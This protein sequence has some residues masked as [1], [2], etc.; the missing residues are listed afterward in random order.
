M[1][2]RHRLEITMAK[3]LDVFDYLNAA[4]KED[5]YTGLIHSAFQE[6]DVFKARFC[7]FFGAKFDDKAKLLMRHPFYY[8]TTIT[9]RKIGKDGRIAQEPHRHQRQIPDLVLVTQDKIC[10]IESKLFSSE[11]SFQTERYGDIRFLESIKQEKKLAHLNLETAKLHSHRCQSLSDQ[12]LFYMTINGDQAYNTSFMSVTWSDLI[13]A[14]LPE[15]SDHNEILQP[16]LTQMKSRFV[17]Y[18]L[19]RSEIVAAK[20]DQALDPFLRHSSKHFL[21]SKDYLLFAFFDELKAIQTLLKDHLGV[22]IESATIL[23]NRQ[24]LIAAQDWED[25]SIEAVLETLPL[26]TPVETI[27][28]KLIDEP[29]PFSRPVIKVINNKKICVCINYEPNPYLSET[30]LIKRYGSKLVERLQQGKAQ[31][32]TDLTALGIVTTSSLLQVCKTEFPKN[33]KDL[34]NKVTDQI[35]QYCLILDELTKKESP[36]E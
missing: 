15:V 8:E 14:V 25:P 1:P 17:S 7:A 16:I 31:F 18:P 27:L 32:I 10:I 23:G 26:G 24:L 35:R 4:E 13:Q 36:Y 29:Y 3:I 28:E 11:G 9:K 5:I 33:D 2:F 12:C 21:L 34:V 19:V 30:K 6:S 22:R 20:G